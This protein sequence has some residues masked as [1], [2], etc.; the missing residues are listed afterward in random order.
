MVQILV[1]EDDA[2][3]RTDIVEFLELQNYTPIEAKDGLVGLQIAREVLPDLILCDGMMPYLDGYGVLIELRQDS[4]TATIPFIFI[5]ARN[6]REDQRYGMLLGADDYITKPFAF[7]ELLK[8][9]QVR[10]DKSKQHQIQ[11]YRDLA[12]S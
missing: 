6:E 7:D 3:I 8:V 4:A 5:T 2:N 10:L 12:R 9:I 1:I 11:R